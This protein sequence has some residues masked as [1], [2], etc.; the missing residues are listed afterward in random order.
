M[1]EGDSPVNSGGKR[2]PGSGPMMCKGPEAGM[3]Y[4]T[5]RWRKIIGEGHEKKSDL[6]ESAFF[7]SA[8]GILTSFK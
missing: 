1:L 5:D 3:I 6:R 7:K 4:G 2:T 8:M